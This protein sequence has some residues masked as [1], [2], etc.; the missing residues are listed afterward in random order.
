[1][2]PR[3]AEPDEREPP[4]LFPHTASIAV[5]SCKVTSSNKNPGSAQWRTESAAKSHA[6]ALHSAFFS[7]RI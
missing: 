6:A 3:R 5:S 7:G 2:M 4:Y 1:M